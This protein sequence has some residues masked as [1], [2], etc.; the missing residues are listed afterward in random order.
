MD[1]PEADADVL[2]D[3][4]PEVRDA[5]TLHVSRAQPRV[6]ALRLTTIVATALVFVVGWSLGT[7]LV[8]PGTDT[9]SAKVAE[10]ARHHDLGFVVNDLEKVQ[11]HFTKPKAGG[12]P[13]TGIPI[14]AAPGPPLPSG[15]TAVPHLPAPPPIPVPTGVTPVADEG[16]WQT[17]ATVKGLPAIRITE[18][19]PDAT[20]TSVLVGVAWMDTRLTTGVLHPGTQ[21]PGGTWR[22]PSK[23]EEPLESTVLAAFNSGFTLKD[24]RGGY[25]E[26]GRVYHPLRNGAATLAILKDGT[27][28]V[29]MWGRDLHLGDVSAARQN[30]DL[31][32]DHGRTDPSV[33]EENTPKWGFTLGNKKFVPRSAVGVLPDGALVYV[34]GK[35]MSTR[36]LAQLCQ[37]IGMV[38]A[39]ELDINPE[40][41]SYYWFSH[42][43]HQV[44][45]HKLTP[46]VY[47]PEDRYFTV[48]TRDFFTVGPR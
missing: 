48:S 12:R 3:V 4:T 7:A 6:L 1:N 33:D 14:V 5:G 44:T 41:V 31:L 17:V 2:P 23:I 36:T 28:T 26:E 25:Y 35:A 30:L 13:A 24:N 32:V 43:G 16:Q 29:G 42:Q 45:S 18:V 19:R 38:R 9:T 8:A 39:M 11:Y 20:Y 46:D 27:M 10:W 15:S 40:W 47:K 22:T 34:G 21:E 37:R